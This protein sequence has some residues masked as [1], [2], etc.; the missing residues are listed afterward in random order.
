MHLA[1]TLF[2][3]DTDLEHFDATK[4]ETAMEAHEAMQSTACQE[5][6]ADASRGQCGATRGDATT[7]RG[8]REGG[9]TR[10]DTTTRQCV[11]RRLRVKRLQ[12]DKKPCD[13]QPGKWEATARQ[14]VLAH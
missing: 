1:G 8:K 6:A 5:A 7:S 3:D 2:V 14:E 9:A 4:I 10:G 11:E 13:N 12:H